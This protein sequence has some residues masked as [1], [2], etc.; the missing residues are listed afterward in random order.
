M[1]S[2]R[3][4]EGNPKTSRRPRKPF[5]YNTLRRASGNP[6]DLRTAAM[7]QRYKYISKLAGHS[8]EMVKHSGTSV[9]LLCIFS[10]TDPGFCEGGFEWGFVDSLKGTFEQK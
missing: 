8:R 2:G 7:Y 10:G 5:E 4:S 6:Q 1:S 9:W 3:S